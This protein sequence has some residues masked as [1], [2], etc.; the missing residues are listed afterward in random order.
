MR[1]AVGGIHTESSTFS[2]LPTDLEDFHVVRGEGLSRDRRFRALEELH[3]VE[4]LPT[5][6]ARAL[7]GGPVATEA[8]TALKQEFLERLRVAMPVDGLY[9]AMHGAMN[10]SGMD[11]AEG[12]WITAAREVVGPDCVMIASY[13]LHGNVSRRIAGALDGMSAYRTAPH[14]DVHETHLRAARMLRRALSDGVRPTLAW[15]PIPVLLPGERTSTEDQPAKRLYAG[16]RDHDAVDG[17]WDASLL[18]GYVWADEPRATASAVV[19]GTDAEVVRREAEAIAR[20]YWN[21]RDEFAFG[22]RHGDLDACLDAALAEAPAADVTGAAIVADSG[23]N[24]TA[25]GVG[26]RADAL[27]GL[28]ERGA[29]GVLVAGIAA[30]DAVAAAFGTTEGARLRLPVGAQL[31]EESGPRFEIDAEVVRLVHAEAER[32]REVLVRTGGITVALGA[33]RRPYHHLEDFSRLGVDPRS[34]R[35]LVVKSGYLAPALAPLAHPSLLALS[36]GAVSQDIAHLGHTRV[37][38]PFFPVDDAFDWAPEGRGSGISSR[39]R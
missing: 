25:G 13:D 39:D 23:D 36:D 8:Y 27:V 14:I 18:V 12:D 35:V 1:I 29:Q 34:Y 2:P 3:D 4:I 37:P 21:A 32:D 16:L 38:R 24:P 33:R 5:L 9:L 31:A 20:S 22:P 11:D 10:V 17:V 19:T 15:V 30:P 26:D 6:H 7:P 28:V